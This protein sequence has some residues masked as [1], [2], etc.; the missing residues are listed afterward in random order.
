MSESVFRFRQFTVHQDKC[1]MKVGTD[2]VLLGSW[3]NAERTKNILDIG[4]GTGIIA[5]MLAQKSDAEIDA[6]DIDLNACIQ[7]EENVSASAWAERIHIHN[8]SFQEFSSGTKKKYDLI[9]SNP[10]YFSDAPKPLTIERI[11]SRHTDRLAFD[12]LIAG[13]KKII[14]PKGKFCVVLPCREGAAFMDE[15]MKQGLFCR[16]ILHVKT[17]IDKQEKRLLMEF[18][19]SLVNMEEKEMVIR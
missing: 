8:V 14:S 16:N 10:P 9:V 17:K 2:A 13:V 11:Q 3:V 4:T 6:V 15:A 12:E 5:M 18:T 1:A 19:P 7:A